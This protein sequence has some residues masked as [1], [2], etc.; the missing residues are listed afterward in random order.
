M[1]ML[2]Y[3]GGPVSNVITVEQIER[4]LAD[5]IATDREDRLASTIAIANLIFEGS[6]L[7]TCSFGTWIERFGIKRAQGFKYK[8]IGQRHSDELVKV[9]IPWAKAEKAKGSAIGRQLSSM[10]D[11]YS[12]P[13]ALYKV[14][15]LYEQSSK[16]PSG[17]LDEDDNVE[18]EADAEVLVS[19]TPP[20]TGA[21]AEGD[22]QV[23]AFDVDEGEEPV[24]VIEAKTMQALEKALAR[25]DAIISKQNAALAAAARE[26][27]QLK[28][29]LSSYETSL[30]A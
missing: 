24:G 27:A 12:G 23:L 13:E 14:V 16:L 8:K 1:L 22:D 19:C 15:M 29:R 18:Q 3:A 9:V 6:R 10:N 26:I 30:A 28:Q 11:D 17:A 7:I 25:K 5:R 4:A 2:T 20:L 21:A